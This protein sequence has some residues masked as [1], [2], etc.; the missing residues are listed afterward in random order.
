[1]EYK[2]YLYST[3]SLFAINDAEDILRQNRLAVP[4]EGVDK[5]HMRHMHQRHEMGIGQTLQCVTSL[6]IIIARDSF[7]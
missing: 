2:H 5:R 3:Q 6:V 7:L 1:M 4:C